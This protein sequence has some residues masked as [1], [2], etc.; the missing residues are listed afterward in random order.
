MGQR[1]YRKRR[2]RCKFVD[3]RSGLR[4]QRQVKKAGSKYCSR[5]HSARSRGPA[6]N[7]PEPGC[8]ARYRK[9]KE[10]GLARVV[11]RLRAL[12]DEHGRVPLTAVLPL[13]DEYADDRYACGYQAGRAKLRFETRRL[14]LTASKDA[15]NEF[16][17]TKLGKGFVAG[18]IRPDDLSKFKFGG[19]R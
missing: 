19:T 11:E 18:D 9:A 1:G 5:S 10:A 3:P 7:R 15:L 12:A 14:R 8:R 2:G 13:L 4:C 17:M 16:L 6:A